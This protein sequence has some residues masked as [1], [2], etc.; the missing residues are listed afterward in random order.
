MLS[1][2]HHFRVQTSESRDAPFLPDRK[3]QEKDQVAM[4]LI[5][6]EL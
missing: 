1:A 3:S 2:I 4:A 6:E 5:T